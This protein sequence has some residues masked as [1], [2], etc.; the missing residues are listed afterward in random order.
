MKR[1]TLLLLVSATIA[2]TAFAQSARMSG[3]LLAGANIS[4]IRSSDGGALDHKWKFGFTGGGYLNFPVSS[5]VSIQPQLQYSQM[6]TKFDSASLKQK[7]NYLSIPVLVKIGLGKGLALVLGPQVDFLMAAKYKDANDNKVD[8]KGNFN[9]TDFAGTAGFQL[10]PNSAISLTARYIHGFTDIVKN[11][12]GVN[13]QVFPNTN[14]HNQAIQATLN[15][16]LFGGPKKTVAV[17]T[18][19]VPETPAPDLC[20][21]DSDHDGVMD[22]NDKCVNVA[23]VAKYNGC[24]I[25]DSDGDGIND[26]EDKCPSVAG[27]ARYQGCP[28]PDSDNDGV[29][30]EEDNCPNLAGPASNHGCPEVDASTQSKVDVMSK[31]IAWTTTTSTTLSTRSNKSL[32][33]IASMLTADPNLKVTIGAHSSNAGDADQNKTM[34]QQR[35]DAI[36]AYLVSKGV[37]ASQIESTGF[38]G[39]QPIADNTTAAGRTKNARVE[40]RLHY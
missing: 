5:S 22:C 10:F 6:G 11:T 8:N 23:G 33:Q 38:G 9:K 19:T 25:P 3:G 39:E 17:T 14:F 18:P 4:N 40:L 20:S 34:T 1:K 26:E 36:K 28:I 12:T 31:N 27:I 21:I 13:S 2:A 37:A 24:P 29:N 30:D 16:R 15:F 35:A 32:D 7:L